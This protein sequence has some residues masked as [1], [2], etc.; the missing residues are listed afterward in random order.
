MKHNDLSDIVNTGLKLIQM[1]EITVFHLPARGPN[2]KILSLTKFKRPVG[3]NQV[4]KQS[5]SPEMA[6]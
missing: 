6:F 1:E 2:D 5:S 4:N 3:D